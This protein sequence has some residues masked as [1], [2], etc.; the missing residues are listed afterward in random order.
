MLLGECFIRCRHIYSDGAPPTTNSNHLYFSIGSWKRW[1]AMA[2]THVL[3]RMPGLVIEAASTQR[4]LLSTHLSPSEIAIR[5][6]R[7]ILLSQI[8]TRCFPFLRSI[9]TKSICTW[10]SP[11]GCCICCWR[12]YFLAGKCSLPKGETAITN[13]AKLNRCTWLQSHA[14]LVLTSFEIQK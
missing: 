11:I 10:F 8:G 3:A 13:H 9:S 6:R 4:E 1:A 2:A 14:A 5:N 7:P 12:S